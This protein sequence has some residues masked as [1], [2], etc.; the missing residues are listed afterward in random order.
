MVSLPH[1]VDLDIENCC[2]VE[3]LQKKDRMDPDHAEWPSVRETLSA[4]AEDGEKVIQEQLRI[5][6]GLGNGKSILLKVF[7]GGQPPCELSNNPFVKSLQRASLFCRWLAAS[8]LPE[9]HRHF[10]D[11]ARDNPGASTLFYMW[12][13]AEDA[14][15]DAW[16]EHLQAFH[17]SHLSLHFDGIRVSSNDVGEAVQDFCAACSRHTEAKAGFKVH[18]RP[19]THGC[20]LQ[21]VTQK[22]SISAALC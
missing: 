15:L 1:T 6:C 9:L 7:N 19:K 10:V 13:V 22:G 14:V 3:M 20:F 2:F 4:C 21:L 12:T 17:P 8:S 16:L 5:C 11:E 18:I